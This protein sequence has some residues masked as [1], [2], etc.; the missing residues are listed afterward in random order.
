MTE[1]SRFTWW[2][3]GL[4]V[5]VVSA[6]LNWKKFFLFIL[7]GVVFLIAGFIKHA[8]GSKSRKKKKALKRRNEKIRRLKKLEFERER[9]RKEN[10]TGEG[11]T[12]LVFL[13]RDI[14]N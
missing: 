6:M 7:V 13:D 1:I 2:F 3:F 12:G 9:I 10:T 14:Q 4:F 11:R 8:K 5:V